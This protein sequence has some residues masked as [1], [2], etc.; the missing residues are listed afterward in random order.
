MGPV[1]RILVGVAVV[2]TSL[3]AFGQ[4]LSAR[5]RVD[6]SGSCYPACQSTQ[7]ANPQNSAVIETPFVLDAY[8]SC[9]CARMVFQLRDEKQV[10]AIGRAQRQ[11]RLQ[12][13]LSTDRSI[14]DLQTRNAAIC[15]RALLG[16]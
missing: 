7:R 5:D 14:S 10:V 3:G 13:Y 8:C 15:Q 4:E 6:I 1:A 2:L 9:T 11:G 12:Q 16:D